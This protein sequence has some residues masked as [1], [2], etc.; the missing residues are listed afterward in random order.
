MIPLHFYKSKHKEIAKLCRKKKYKA[1][2]KV[3]TKIQN[4]RPDTSP[5]SCDFKTISYK[6]SDL[7]ECIESLLDRADEKIN[8]E[9]HQKYNPK[10]LECSGE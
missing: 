9:S 4:K 3:H 7:K 5:G 1:L 10:T 8:N 2:S 6:G